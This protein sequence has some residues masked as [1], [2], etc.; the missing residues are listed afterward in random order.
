MTNKYLPDND[1]RTQL[2]D[3]MAAAMDAHR[4]GDLFMADRLYGEVLGIDPDHLKA[5]RL[6]GILARECGD[7]DKSLALLQRAHT[8]APADPEPLGEIAI[9]QMTVGDL[10]AA[11]HSLRQ[12][13]ALNPQAVRTLVN[14]G[15]LLQH[16][17]HVQTAI[18][19]YEQALELEP[20]DL[21]LHCN[22]AKALADSGQIEDALAQCEKTI[23]FSR[24]HPL[25]LATQ[26]AVLA[27]AARYSDARN[28][29]AEATQQNPYDDMALV[30]LALCCYE[31]GDTVAASSALRQAVAANPL[32]ARAVADLANC[33]TAL[34]DVKG[35]LQLC[36]EFL[37]QQPGERLVVAAQALA[38]LNAG[39]AGTADALTNFAGLI[40]VIDLPCPAGFDN[41]EAF[42][43]ALAKILRSDSSLLKD[44]VSK[45]T[46]G[47]A[48]TGE[49][50]LHTPG[51]LAEFG[52]AVNRAVAAATAEWLA[53]GLQSHPLMTPATQH[54]SLR[55]WGTVLR[56]GGRQ[57]PHMHPLGWISGVYY[58][59][60][61]TDMNSN[62][63][64]AGWLEFGR[65]PERFFG[66]EKPA[67]RRYQPAAG[68]L[69]LFPAWFWH[70][71]IP[72]AA[73][74][75][76]ISIAFDVMQGNMLRS[77]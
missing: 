66:R 75:E 41:I 70:Q 71:T 26:G 68:R 64:E 4:A 50:D 20:D 59:Q 10:Y 61:P 43:D 46:Y 63:P 60:L 8:V 7:I 32:N 76:R 31:M 38:L 5:L 21:Q 13:L 16:R 37:Q 65:P 49:L 62:A 40:K 73:A 47:G 1:A 44:P 11:E 51:V 57:T 67:V 30:N 74:G 52:T 58:V 19:F 33:L 56:A 39:Q 72:F 55:A 24:G 3:V 34:D 45:S 25:A 12:A 2:R 69:I 17:G 23:E 29:L 15:A 6:R 54:W 22:L 77:L 42:N 48:Q 9:A 35:A 36:A 18:T 28:V 53:E 14:L 27:D